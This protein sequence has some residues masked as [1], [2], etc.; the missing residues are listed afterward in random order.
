MQ[1]RSRG[2]ALP[3]ISPY[4]LAASLLSAGAAFATSAGIDK[5]DFTTTAE[6]A[7]DLRLASRMRDVDVLEHASR[8]LQAET[9]AFALTATDLARRIEIAPRGRQRIAFLFRG[10]TADEA[11]AIG[12]AAIEAL[13][14]SQRPQGR[15]KQELRLAAAQERQLLQMYLTATNVV[16]AFM[17]TQEE[18]ASKGS[19]PAKYVVG[20]V[21]TFVARLLIRVG[22]HQTSS[23]DLARELRGMEPGSVIV[24]PHTPEKGKGAVSGMALSARLSALVF[25]VVLVAGQ[26][27]SA[28]RSAEAATIAGGHPRED[29]R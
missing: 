17:T 18:A 4:W 20:I 6:L 26:A 7:I 15:R 27:L 11:V 19:I 1:F 29:A 10:D 5:P 28:R 21:R 16:L 9:P 22:D 8:T 23:R 12:S 14:D 25:L 24:R 13:A 3:R 2:T